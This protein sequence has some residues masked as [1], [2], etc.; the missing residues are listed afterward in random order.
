MRNLQINS[1]NITN[2]TNNFN[3][4][5]TNTSI[6]TTSIINSSLSKV[7]LYAPSIECWA[8]AYYVHSIFSILVSI[9]FIILCII[10]QMT[11]FETKFSTVNHSAKS[12]SKADVFK[13]ISKILTLILFQFFEEKNNQWVLI[14]VIFFLSAI[15]FFTYF[16][17]MPYYND[18]MM[19]VI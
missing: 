13:L 12:N 9:F 14:I 17:E 19:K 4:T 11:F 18:R 1:T 10:V 7:N 3:F 5:L 15:M 6:T 2:I 8:G 16:E